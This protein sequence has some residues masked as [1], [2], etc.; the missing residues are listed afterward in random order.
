MTQEQKDKKL[1][2]IKFIN[3]LKLRRNRTKSYKRHTKLKQQIAKLT[4]IYNFKY[5]ESL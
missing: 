5:N 1:K 3:E 2:D 4:E